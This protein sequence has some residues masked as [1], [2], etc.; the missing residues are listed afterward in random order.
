[1]IK[2]F[3]VI[4]AGLAGL[5]AAAV[6]REECSEIL[7]AQ[8]HLPNNHSALLRFRTDAVGNS[9]NIRFR[10][11]VVL[12]AVQSIGNPIAD[13]IAYSVKTNGT[14]TMRSLVGARG[15]SELRFIA[16]PNLVQRM[17]EKVTCPINFGAVWRPKAGLG[18]AT[19]STIPMPVL[20]RMLDY[21]DIP[22]FRYV[23]GYSAT[24]RLPNVDLCATLYIP[25]PEE[26]EYRTSITDD[27]LIIEYA[28]P[29]IRESDTEELERI[30][31]V[32]WS[33]GDHLEKVLRR[34]G[35]GLIASHEQVKWKHQQYAKIL[36]ID[37]EVR[38]HFIMW[39]TERYGIYSF[40]RFATWRPGLM[41]DDLVN[42]LRVIQR[43]ANGG[44]SYDARRAKI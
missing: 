8:P 39:A 32:L 24:V 33:S 6:L 22:Q 15:E 23:Q 36:P 11:V 25:A 10:E 40:G 30:M 44:S 1:M 17:A 3:Q 16:P 31:K 29:D 35:L 20:M 9:L 18:Q 38:K 43:L 5:F 21:P 14:A 12:K 2:K 4:G 19:I 28:F 42:D 26:L 41:M 13:A 27:R 37:S 34:F 7:E